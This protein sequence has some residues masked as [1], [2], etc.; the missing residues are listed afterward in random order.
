MEEPV[1]ASPWLG[2]GTT[3]LMLAAAIQDDD[4]FVTALCDAGA[5]VDVVD[6]LNGESAL[7]YAVRAGS[8][9]CIRRLAGALGASLTLKNKQGETVV[10]AAAAEGQ[11]AVLSALLGV[12]AAPD[13]AF[14][15]DNFGNTPLIL[16][17]RFGHTACVHALI[18]AARGDKSLVD[19]QSTRGMTAVMAACFWNHVGAL[20][21]LD[22]AGAALDLVD[23]NGMDV[24]AMAIWRNSTAALEYLLNGAGVKVDGRGEMG[25][26]PLCM[27]TW[28]GSTECALMLAA[29]C[30]RVIN[31]A[32][33]GGNTPL[34]HGA[35]TAKVALVTA[36]LQKY[37]ADP[38]RRNAEGATPLH[39]AAECEDPRCLEVLLKSCPPLSPRMTVSGSTP[40]LSAIS[41]GRIRCTLA[42]LDAGVSPMECSKQGHTA[43]EVAA[44]SGRLELVKVLAPRVKATGLLGGAP[45]IQAASLAFR[46]A[47]CCAALADA[48]DIMSWLIHEAGVPP[49]A[50]DP[51]GRYPLHCAAASGSLRGIGILMDECF[52]SPERVD[53]ATLTPLLAAATAGYLDAVKLLIEHG[54][55]ISGKSVPEC[56]FL[57]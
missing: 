40:L 8:L 52:V 49:D 10:H 4:S 51:L 27:A 50:I 6:T 22:A 16:A 2:R 46:S 38:G 26:T 57:L 36:F 32:D 42:L 39:F 28:N 47:L 20:R 29:A 33:V 34:H 23:C 37:G 31:D 17:A 48:P 18:Q 13:V 1:I 30:P 11:V 56:W 15:R 5:S 41:R 3:A 43:L 53:A 55:S 25:M 12:S 21:C 24:V 9:A 14:A 35:R 54:A 7:F 19:A 45:A 44:Q